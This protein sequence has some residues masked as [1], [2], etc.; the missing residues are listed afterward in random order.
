MFIP[1]LS[2]KNWV[3]GSIEKLCVVTTEKI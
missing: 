3:W 1:A 2:H